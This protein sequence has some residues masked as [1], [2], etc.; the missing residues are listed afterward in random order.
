MIINKF[1]SK[2]VSDGSFYMWLESP[3]KGVG[4]SLHGKV[5]PANQVL[6]N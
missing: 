1:Q 3:K 2:A 5:V 4:L 6:Q